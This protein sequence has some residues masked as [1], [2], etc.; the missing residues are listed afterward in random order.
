MTLVRRTT[1]PSDPFYEMDRLFNRAFGG[2]E[3]WPE[4][5]APSLGRDFPLDVYG[6]DDRYYVVAEMPGVAK[7]SIDLKVENSVLTITVD[8]NEKDEE[9]TRRRQLSRSITVGD[10]IDMDNV[11][12][13]LENGLLT[14][15]LPKAEERKPRKITIG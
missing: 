11:C 5:F 2:K 13:K 1:W 15:T 6:D 12:A 9:M 7:D 14:V 3:F 4:A 8:R 10:D